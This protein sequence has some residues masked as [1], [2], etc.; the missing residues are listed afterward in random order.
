VQIPPHRIDKKTITEPQLTTK[1]WR[2]LRNLNSQIF[3]DHTVDKQIQ[4]INTI[5]GII[6]VISPIRGEP[7][8]QLSPR[9]S[10]KKGT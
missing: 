8:V 9:K 10:D 3:S 1:I 4:L 7:S 6:L 5:K 2:E